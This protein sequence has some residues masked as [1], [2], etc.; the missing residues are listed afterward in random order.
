MKAASPVFL[1]KF[2]DQ[3]IVFA[4]D[5]EYFPL[6]A[7]KIGDP[8]HGIIL[9]RWRMSWRER[10]QALIRGDVYLQVMTFNQPLQPV[11][12]FVERPKEGA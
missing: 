8:D 12:I 1:E 10:L 9:T 5:P 6:P 4:K 7:L 3:E 11:S 2:V